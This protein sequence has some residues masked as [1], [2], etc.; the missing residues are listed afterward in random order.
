MDQITGLE[1]ENMEI[2][3]PNHILENAGLGK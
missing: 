1:N 3:G 2:G